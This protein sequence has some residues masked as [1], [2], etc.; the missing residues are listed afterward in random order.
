MWH[1]WVWM[2]KALWY[3]FT[4]TT[5]RSRT[6]QRFP[7][8][9][10]RLRFLPF[11]LFLI[12]LLSC[13]PTERVWNEEVGYRWAA[14]EVEGG[15]HAEFRQQA[16]TGIT[17]RNDLSEEALVLNR[18]LL[19]GSGVAAGDIDGDGWVDLYFAGLE[20]PNALYRNLGDWQFEEI[21]EQAGVGASGRFS[22]GAVFAD[23]DGDGD[24]DLF[25]TAMGGPNA[26]F[27]ND[28]M[29]SFREVT[30]D[31]GLQSSAGSTSMALA[32]ADGDG[33]L[34][35]YVANYKRVALRD[36]LPPSVIGW[37]Q[38]VQEGNDGYEVAP[39]FAEHYRL[40]VK[41]TKV[42]RL[43]KGEADRFYLNDG[44]GHFKAV[45]FTSGAFLDEAGKPFNE[46]PK[47]WALAVRFQ[48]IN[49]DGAPD[50]YVCN[51]FESPDYFWLNQGDGTFRAIDPFAVRKTSN[52]TMSVDFA[53][54]NHDDHLDFFLA[55]MLSPDPLRRRM[56]RATQA[57]I[58][59]AIG[60]I[61]QRQQIMQ[62]TLFVNRGD[63]SYAEIANFSGVAASE[64]S[65]SS[66][67]LDVDL[68]GYEDLLI[69]NGHAY[70]VQ[71]IDALENERRLMQRA[72][73]FD[74]FRRIILSFPSLPLPNM[75]FRN[76]G[77]LTFE[78][79]ES[80]WGLGSESD[81]SHGM[82]L[83]DLDNDG[84][85][86]VVTNRLNN[87]ASLYE[88]RGTASRIAVRLQ[89]NPP[90]TQGIGATIRVLGGPVSQQKQVV[91]GGAYL[92][93]NDPLYSFAAFDDN[94]ALQI[95]VIWRSGRVSRVDSVQANRLY[96]VH[97]SGS[98]D[99]PE[100]ALEA[101][102]VSLFEPVILN[103]THTELP[104]DDSG[105]QTLLT[106]KL[107]QQGPPV[108]WTDW[109]KDG[110]DELFIGSGRGGALAVFEQ[111]DERF[112][113]IPKARLGDL[114]AIA[115]LDQTSI[116][117]VET[118]AGQAQVLVGFA[119][120]ESPQRRASYIS[121]Y[122]AQGGIWREV[123]RLDAGYASLGSLAVADIDGDGDGDLFAA[124]QFLPAQYPVSASSYVFKQSGG[125]WSKNEEGSIAFQDIG[126]VNAADFADLD[127]DGDVDLVLATEW[128]PLHVFRNE[129]DGQFAR[130]TQ[131]YG[132]TAYTGW[133]R[134][135]RAAD[136]NGDGQIDVVA[137]NWGWNTPWGYPEKQGKPLRIQH[138]D[139][140]GNGQW[141]LVESYWDPNSTAYVPMLRMDQLAMGIPSIQRHIRRHADFATMDVDAVLGPMRANV[142]AREASMLG[143]TVFLNR[144]THFEPVALPNE[145]Q[146]APASGVVVA[147]FNKD[148]HV[149]V[150]LAQNMFALHVD[151]P[152]LDS[153]RGL[154]FL[155]DGYGQFTPMS[156]EASGIEAY[157]DQRHVAASDF[158]GDGDMD[159]VITQNGAATQLYRNTTVQGL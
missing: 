25:V 147:D 62:N 67:F 38:V 89:G 88:N 32:D 110:K 120:Y 49:G 152:R 18:H 104:F 158:D 72:H 33:D 157:G 153:G 69:T 126:L 74:Q 56:Q 76:N 131:S 59:I 133:W 39:D 134:G 139:M 159:L 125:Q 45:S 136:V 70:D 42:F 140:D 57:P 63:G 27:Q 102:V 13:Q 107:S 95:E 26:V 96:E 79:M 35:L 14:L 43:E 142:S 55:D 2:Q 6:A 114:G 144:G 148:G 22:T 16:R 112:S 19:N 52:S 105:M 145:A 47:D 20:G 146:W 78:T 137:T 24:L 97:E 128:G 23:S 155:G 100:S 46:A 116:Q 50:L 103:H 150:V 11:T 68:D 28:G 84:D 4:C 121:V 113:A 124:G 141:D 156:G 60:D 83:A 108:A 82:A 101:P 122:E 98:K 118:E 37:E 109:N 143:H 61:E 90:N 51:D 129:G 135:I 75:A 15:Q 154:I 36:S 8:S 54:L 94:T 117:V 151:I 87:T 53:D 73:S 58:P 12:L 71:N 93:G 86:D 34:D 81:I 31:V 1:V 41:G 44:R 7:V 115:D 111:Q 119:N 127:A 65:W 77:D 48:D 92:S 66:Q 80:G 5:Y 9:N 149:D 10:L 3:A 64:W 91:S 99:A 29:G 40:V 132:L 123:Q 21:T 17:F 30:A 106:R 130:V 85:L 138:G